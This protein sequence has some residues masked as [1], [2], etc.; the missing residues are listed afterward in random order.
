[1]QDRLFKYKYAPYL[2]IFLFW[3]IIA[4]LAAT[5]LFVRFA[6]TYPDATWWGFFY[7][8]SPI[9][10]IWMFYTPLILWMVSWLKS[11]DISFAKSIL[12]HLL[13]A[14]IMFVIYSLLTGM[15]TLEL[16]QKL[17]LSFK[18]IFPAASRNFAL[19]FASNCLIYLMIAFV[20]VGLQWY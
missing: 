17:T 11:R 1:M 12:M 5:F 16:N 15:H 7:R 8:Q 2:I 14:S 4:V 18:A 6:D 10:Y 3:N 9:W 20:G 19:N 13:M